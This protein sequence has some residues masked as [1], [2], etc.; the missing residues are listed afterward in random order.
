M[1]MVSGIYA[2]QRTI[3]ELVEVVYTADLIHR[4][5]L[6]LKDRTD[7]QVG[8][9]SGAMRWIV[10]LSLKISLF[11]DFPASSGWEEVVRG[12]PIEYQHF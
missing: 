8:D 11:S 10:R 9:S 3:A 12:S 5:L 4:G 2:S 7:F 1:S 6:D